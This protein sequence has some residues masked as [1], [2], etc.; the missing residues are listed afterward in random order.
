M[1]VEVEVDIVV[2]E[3]STAAEEVSLAEDIVVVTE[4]VV[5]VSPP[6]RSREVDFPTRDMP[7]PQ[8]LDNLATS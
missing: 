1:A 4:V 3:A 2:D 7:I 6:T 5:E 8:G